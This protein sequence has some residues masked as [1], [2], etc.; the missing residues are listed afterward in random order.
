MSHHHDDTM[1]AA[2]DEV[3]WERWRQDEKWGEQNHDLLVWH[4]ILSEEVGEFAEALLTAR[5]QTGTGDGGIGQVRA[6][7]IQV[8]AVAVAII[9][10]IDRAGGRVSEDLGR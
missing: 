9:E 10:H 8:A 1:A 6:E 2:L 5:L 7:I 4:A 3:T